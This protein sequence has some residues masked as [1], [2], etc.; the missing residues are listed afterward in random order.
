M[1]VTDQTWMPPFIALHF[2]FETRFLIE[3]EYTDSSSLAGQRTPEVLLVLPPCPGITD[4]CPISSCLCGYWGSE[5]RYML[6]CRTLSLQPSLDLFKTFLD[7]LVH[8]QWFTH[9]VF[10]DHCKLKPKQ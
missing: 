2:I 9:V 1:E 8:D 5:L 7:V 6:V 3:P 10:K 4:L